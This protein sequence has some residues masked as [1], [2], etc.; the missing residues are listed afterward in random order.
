V[1]RGRTIDNQEELMGLIEQERGD[2]SQVPIFPCAISL[3]FR[4][5][6]ESEFPLG[7]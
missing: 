2:L 7:G 3:P 6:K 5:I 1:N 4:D